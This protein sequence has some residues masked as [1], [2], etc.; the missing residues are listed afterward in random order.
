QASRTII[1]ESI[2]GSVTAPKQEIGAI[3][4]DMKLPTHTYL[5]LELQDLRSRVRRIVGVFDTGD[6]IAP[7]PGDTPQN[8]DYHERGLQ[9]AFH[10]LLGDEWAVGALYRFTRSKYSTSFPE[11]PVGIYPPARTRQEAD[12]HQVNLRLQ[13]QHSG[14]FFARAEADWY[15]QDARAAAENGV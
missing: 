15:S 8:L 12:L 11:I 5:G 1:S 6:I 14:G 3:A 9:F 13:Y 10:Q 4:A 2:A 7:G